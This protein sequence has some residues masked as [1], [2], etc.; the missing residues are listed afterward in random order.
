MMREARQ[1]NA[2]PDIAHALHI[3]QAILPPW[4]FSGSLRLA[5]SAE[6]AKH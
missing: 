5:T 2:P 3:V 4:T 6:H 1:L